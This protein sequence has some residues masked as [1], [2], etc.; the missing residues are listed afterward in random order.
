MGSPLGEIVYRQSPTRICWWVMLR[1]DG[2]RDEVLCTKDRGFQARE[3]GERL[4]RTYRVPF[5]GR[6]K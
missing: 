6:V 2:A 3:E 5:G 1:R 4:S